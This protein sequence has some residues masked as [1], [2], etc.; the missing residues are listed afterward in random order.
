MTTTHSRT[1]FDLIDAFQQTDCPVCRLVQATVQRYLESINYE[2]VNDPGVRAEL[3]R[4]RGFCPTHAAQWL[5]LAHPLGTALIYEPILDQISRELSALRPGGRGRL[6][7][8]VAAKLGARGGADAS[9]DGGDLLVAP[10]RCPACREQGESERMFLTVLVD[11]LRDPDFQAAYERSDTLC[12]PHLRRVFSLGIE[13]PAF[14]V[15]RDAGLARQARL[16]EQLREVIRKHDYRT[17]GEPAGDERGASERAVHH[18]A[19][20]AMNRR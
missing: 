19:A 16:R 17:H 12:V 6:L 3:E 13:D 15:L 5:S 11:G 7:S 20:P 2:Y 18:V 9:P 10:G 4:A 14:S 1:H 8:S